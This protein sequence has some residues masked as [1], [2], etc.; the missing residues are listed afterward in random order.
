ML[1]SMARSW[2]ELFHDGGRLTGTRPHVHTSSTSS[3]RPVCLGFCEPCTRFREARACG[4]DNGLYNA[5]P[6]HGK[7]R[8]PNDDIDGCVNFFDFLKVQM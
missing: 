7:P 5:P 6:G 2:A 3:G 4:K 1:I 8:E